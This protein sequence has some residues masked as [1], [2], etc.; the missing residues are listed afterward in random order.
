MPKPVRELLRQHGAELVLHGH[1][2]EARWSGCRGRALRSPAS[3]CRPPPARSAISDEPGA[4]NLYE[5]DGQPGAWRCTMTARGFS[6]E[7]GIRL[8]DRLAD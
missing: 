5:I 2:H 4:Y 8:T 7:A 1:H 3:A 6:N